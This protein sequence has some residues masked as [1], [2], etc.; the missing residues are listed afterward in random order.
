M[1]HLFP[2][3]RLIVFAKAPVPGRVKTRLRPVLGAGAARLYKRLCLSVLAVA[4]DSGAAPLELHAAPSR[5]HPWL[6]ARARDLS[7]SLRVQRPGDLGRKMARALGQALKG[8]PMAVIIGADCGGL[9]ADTIRR[10]FEVLDSGEDMVVTPAEDGGY[11]LVGARQRINPAI[12]SGIDWG[13]ERVLA[14]TRRNARRLGI[15]LA[16]IDTSWDV[17]RWPDVR[18]W[19]REHGRSAGGDRTQS[20]QSR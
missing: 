2:A 13:T 11:V 14:Q 6:R 15:A 19:H 20:S 5:G 4:A 1:P 9:R 18:R 17:D 7:A 3:A 16:E 10:A 8:A 12:F